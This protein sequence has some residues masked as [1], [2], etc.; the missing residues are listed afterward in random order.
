MTAHRIDSK[1]VENLRSLLPAEVLSTG[2]SQLDLHAHDQS[3]HPPHR[4]DAVIWPVDASEVSRVLRY[5]NDHG[6]PVTGWGSGSSL[7][8]NPIP[9]CSGIVLDFSQ[10]NQVLALRGSYHGKSHSAVAITG[11]RPMMTKA[12]KSISNF[13]LR[14]G[15]TVGMKVTLRGDRMYEFLDRL[16]NIALPRG[17][18][19]RGISGKAFDG[20][21]NYT[22]G[23]TEQLIFPEI[24]YDKVDEP[25]GMNVT[26]VTTA[27]NDEEGRELLRLMGMPFR[28]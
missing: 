10:M 23:V 5:A 13:K 18:D 22:F 8:G 9:V 15:M 27:N 19:F 2:S 16:I 11:Q 26:I 25:R 7:E 6:I 20:R 1:H 24:D 12:R 14:E 28:R 21:G 3:Q 17:R 4:P